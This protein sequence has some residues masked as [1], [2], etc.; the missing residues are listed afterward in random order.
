MYRGRRRPTNP[1]IVQI[2]AKLNPSFGDYFKVTWASIAVSISWTQACLYFGESDRE[3]YRT[4]PGPTADLQNPLLESAVKKRWER[5]LQEGMLK[6]PDLSFSTLSWA[7][8]QSMPLLLSEQPEARQPTEARHPTEADSVPPGFARI[9][10]KAP[11]EQEA[12]RYETPADSKQSIDEVLGIQHVT[13]ITEDWYAQLV[14]ASAVKSVLQ[15]MEVDEPSE[16]PPRIS[17]EETPICWDRT[18]DPAPWSQ[19][20]RTGPSIQL[21][22]SPEFQGT[23]DQS[24]DLRLAPPADGLWDAPQRDRCQDLGLGRRPWTPKKT[25]DLEEDDGPEVS[26]MKIED[27]EDQSLIF[28]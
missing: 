26:H 11:E 6:T 22:D 3:R 16:E 25:L 15:P 10:Q 17:N 24:P 8:A 27:Q 28:M 12:L 19:P 14:L 2:R 18:R 4:E 1:M 7:G 5:Y 13:N 21:V 23:E 20:R 9:H